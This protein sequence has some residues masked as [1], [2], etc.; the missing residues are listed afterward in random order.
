M[1]PS[2]THPHLALE[3][4][5]KPTHKPRR[6]KRQLAIGLR[7]QPTP[8]CCRKGLAYWGGILRKMRSGFLVAVLSLSLLC[9]IQAGLP[10]KTVDDIIAYRGVT[11][12]PSNFSSL[13]RWGKVC[14]ILAE[15]RDQSACGSCYAVSGASAATDRFCIAHNGTISPRLSE[16]DLMSCCKTCAGSNGGC[17][18]GTP[19]KCWDYMTSQVMSTPSPPP[20]P[21]HRHHHPGHYQW[22]GLWGLLPVPRIPL[23]RVRAPHDW[24]KA[25]VLAY[26]ILRP[27]LLLGM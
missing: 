22:R 3:L 17:D 1:I 15:I 19:S 7:G 10:M 11:P 26:P 13:D 27:H 16:V 8:F 2:I 21:D 14:P 24:V 23:P 18:G 4:S 6:G 9:L 5:R 12:I 20:V 25:D